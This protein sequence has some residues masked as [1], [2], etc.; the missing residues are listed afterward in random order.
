M[1]TTC[2]STYPVARFREIYGDAATFETARIDNRRVNELIWAGDLDSA[3]PEQIVV[4]SE[5]R[6]LYL[7]SKDQQVA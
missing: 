3:S 6:A 5:R 2:P 1:Q 7:E 4:M